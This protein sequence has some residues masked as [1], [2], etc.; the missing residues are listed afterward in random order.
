MK[1]QSLNRWYY[2][3]LGSI[4]M[5]CLGTVYSYSVFRLPVEKLFNIGAT[6]SGMPYMTSLAFYAFFMFLSGRL[7]DK[8]N[9]R[10]II[11]TGGLLVSLGWL[12]SLCVSIVVVGVM[13]YN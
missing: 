1:F 2:V 4:I 3:V 13:R 9:P 11:I 5:M 6:Q 7:L 12:L 8:F 10:H